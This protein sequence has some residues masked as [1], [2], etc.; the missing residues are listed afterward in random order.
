MTMGECWKGG[1]S[2]VQMECDCRDN[3]LPS[4]LCTMTFNPGIRPLL[5]LMMQLLGVILSVRIS[6][7]KCHIHLREQNC[8]W[9]LL[10]S[11]S[12]ELCPSRANLLNMTWPMQELKFS[13]GSKFKNHQGWTRGTKGE[14]QSWVTWSLNP[15]I[16]YVAGLRLL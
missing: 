4:S 6:S 12:P 11:F 9:V 1:V 14:K 15:I 2:T 3:G 10:I 13:M 7:M 5:C 16:Q 8:E